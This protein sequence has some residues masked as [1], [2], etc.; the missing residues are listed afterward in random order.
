MCAPFGGLCGGGDATML[1]SERH[2]SSQ[3]ATAPTRTHMLVHH[4]RYSRKDRGHVYAGR[5]RSGLGGRPRTTHSHRAAFCSCSNW[6]RDL[7]STSEKAINVAM[8]PHA[9]LPAG[10]PRVQRGGRRASD[11]G[12][13]APERR[14]DPLRQGPRGDRRER[15]AGPS[16]LVKQAA[17]LEKLMLFAVVV[18]IVVVVGLLFADFMISYVHFIAHQI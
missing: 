3:R 4:V 7:A 5:H 6:P 17:G 13:S 8:I 11:H 15:D 10:P 18:G 9:E 2:V 1:W 14:R 16:R 12:D